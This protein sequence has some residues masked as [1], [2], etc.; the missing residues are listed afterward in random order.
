[1]WYE[2]NALNKDIE[3]QVTDTTLLNSSKNANQKITL[4]L[5][6]LL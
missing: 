1:M 3:V 6:A 4:Q 2:F 5:A